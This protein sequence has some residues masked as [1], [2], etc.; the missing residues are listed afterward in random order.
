MAKKPLKLTWSD[1][2]EL[3]YLLIDKY[4]Q[5]DPSK[6]SF[7]KI[8]EMV[9]ALPEFSGGKAKPDI[10]LLEDLQTR[11][12]GERS[13]MEDELGPVEN[14][15][16]EDSELDEDIYRADRMI[17]DEDDEEEDEDEFDSYDDEFEDEEDEY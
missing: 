3:A 13:E 14:V 15:E 5:T 2:K 12:A 16:D 9:Q 6:L 11:W 7:G 8:A 1:T 17:E 4:P 10:D